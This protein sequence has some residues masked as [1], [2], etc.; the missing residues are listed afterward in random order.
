MYLFSCIVIII[1]KVNITNINVD[2]ICTYSNTVTI[3]VRAQVHKNKWI[4]STP[5]K[6][7]NRQCWKEYVWF[8]TRVETDTICNQRLLS[9]NLPFIIIT[10]S[11]ECFVFVTIARLQTSNNNNNNNAIGKLTKQMSGGRITQ[12]VF[13]PLRDSRVLQLAQ[14]FD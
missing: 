3:A 6:H 12:I 1:F 14:E 9:R 4:L 11:F 7:I 2:C 13:E 5:T 8:F 10:I